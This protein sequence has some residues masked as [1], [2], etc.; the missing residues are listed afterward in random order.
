MSYTQAVMKETLRL[1]PL[2]PVQT[3]CAA[4]DLVVPLSEPVRTKDGQQIQEIPLKKGTRV[5]LSVTQ[6]NRHPEL[7]GADSQEWNPDRWLKPGVIDDSIKFGV[8][9]NLATFGAGIHACIGWR[10]AIYEFQTFLIELVNKFQFELTEEAR[11][12]QPMYAGIMVPLLKGKDHQ[13]G[14]PLSVSVAA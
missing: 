11:T 13:S 14:L 6:Y 9:S 3:R 7:W 8:F 1:D 5:L 12:A 4:R 2:V 10:F